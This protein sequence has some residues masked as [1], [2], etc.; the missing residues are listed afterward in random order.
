MYMAPAVIDRPA[1]D[2]LQSLKGS[3]IEA[4]RSSQLFLSYTMRQQGKRNWILAAFKIDNVQTLI[5]G[6]SKS[7][8]RLR[9]TADSC[10]KLCNLSCRSN[11]RELTQMSLDFHQAVSEQFSRV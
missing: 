8:I 3:I 2:V 9:Q 6:I 4:Y 7:E 11:M 5:N 1:D 10:E